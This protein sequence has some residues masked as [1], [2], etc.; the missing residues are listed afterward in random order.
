MKYMLVR[1][2]TVSFVLL[3][4][5]VAMAAEKAVPKFGNSNSKA[6]IEINADTLEVQQEKNIAIFTGHVVA[7]QDTMRLKSEKM[8]VYYTN[9]EG[10]KKDSQQDAIRKIEVEGNVFMSTPDETARGLTGVYDVENNKI[11]LNGK[12]VLTKGK[13]TLKGDKLVYDMATGKSVVSAA[14]GTVE[15]GGKSKERVRALFVPEDKD[16]K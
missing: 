9:P 11:T 15:K 2:C 14:G 10:E 12:V 5:S 8:T 16:K 3:S 6:P 4:A 1:F 13:N 7:I